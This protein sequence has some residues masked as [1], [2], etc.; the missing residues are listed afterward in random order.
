MNL[1]L[2]FAASLFLVCTA[3]AH[4]QTVSRHPT[5]GW[6]ADTLETARE[7]WLYAQMSNNA[8]KGRNRSSFI[9]RLDPLIGVGEPHED[10][11]Y[12]L[13]YVVFTDRRAGRTPETVLAFR[14]TQFTHWNDWWQGNLLGSQNLVGAGVYD[15]LRERLGPEARITVTG[16]SL[17]GG[18]ATHISLNRAD[19]DS[20]V[21]NASPRFWREGS[22]QNN[23]RRSVAEYGEILKLA[24]M[25]G[26]E[27]T[28]IYTSIG[29]T[30]REHAIE[31]HSISRL[32]TCL[33]FIAAYT[34]AEARES[35]CLNGLDV[36][37]PRD[38]ERPPELN[39]AP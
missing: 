11:Y 24:R 21:F 5:A 3:C 39:C 34:S 32:A 38:W 15:V 25:P 27:A 37:W 28:Q 4:A 2:V 9:Y 19:V 18:I 16:H 36:E 20:Y 1:K 14:G 30:R 6:N 17:G 35:L 22:S 23:D 29:C 7:T 31:Q 26:S 33:T 10:P 13:D 12:G 8:Y